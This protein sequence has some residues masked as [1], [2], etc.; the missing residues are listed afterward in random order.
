MDGGLLSIL[1]QLYF[2][3]YQFNQL[4][5]R[6][7]RRN[8]QMIKIQNLVVVVKKFEDL[9]DL[10]GD[11]PVGCKQTVIAVHP[12]RVLI[13]I[14][15]A[16]DGEVLIFVL[17]SACHQ[18]EFGVNLEPLNTADHSDAFLLKAI[19]PEDVRRFVKAGL[20]FHDNGH[21]FSVLDFLREASID[22][23]VRSIKITLYRVARHSAV[24][25]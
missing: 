1:R 10:F 15:R 16:D 2:S 4:F 13:K 25:N 22:P 17:Q 5:S 19:R 18:A 14:S 6:L 24:V 3:P 20:E 7:K 21:F 8:D 12:G 9:P 23:K 11:S